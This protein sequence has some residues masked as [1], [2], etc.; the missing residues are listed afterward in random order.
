M[1]NHDHHQNLFAA[2]NFADEK[3][4]QSWDDKKDG[5]KTIAPTSS[6][7]MHSHRGHCQSDFLLQ[8]V[9]ITKDFE[10]EFIMNDGKI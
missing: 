1:H 5:T 9:R 4:V 6:N 3:G 7:T 8:C 10:I 2:E